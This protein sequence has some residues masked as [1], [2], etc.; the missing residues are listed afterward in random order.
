[1]KIPEV[2]KFCYMNRLSR[3]L[4]QKQY[5]ESSRALKEIRGD[6]WENCYTRVLLEIYREKTGNRGFLTVFEG[7]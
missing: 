1:M 7:N 6:I 2:E 4:S 5:L 3:L